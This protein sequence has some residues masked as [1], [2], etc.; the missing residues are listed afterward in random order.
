MGFKRPRVEDATALAATLVLACF[1]CVPASAEVTYEWAR[2]DDTD[3]PP[4]VEATRPFHHLHST[5]GRW[6]VSRVGAVRYVF[7]I[8]KDETTV[9]QY[10][11]FLNAVAADDP[12][13][14]ISKEHLP[15][16]CTAASDSVYCTPPRIVREGSPGSYSYRA[17]PGLERHPVG[18]H[19]FAAA[20]FMNWLHNGQPR[21]PA[22]PDTT[23]SGAYDCVNVETPG[24][25]RF[26]RLAGAR[27]WIPNLHEL[28]K[29]GYWN[30]AT[31]R[32]HWWPTVPGV[33]VD[34]VPLA[35]SPGIN[36]CPNPPRGNEVNT[37]GPSACHTRFVAPHRTR[38]CEFL[39]VA[40]YPATTSPFGLRDVCGQ[41][42][43]LTETLGETNG[44]PDRSKLIGRPPGWWGHPTNDCQAFY[45][46]QTIL[47]NQNGEL[48][49]VDAS[50]RPV[51]TACG[52]IGP[53]LLPLVAAVRVGRAA[54]ARAS[55]RPPRRGSP[56]SH[57]AAAACAS[58]TSRGDSSSRRG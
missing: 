7:E 47:R 19:P 8:S 54:R 4:D 58:S 17:A 56:G 29:A 39:P 14:L 30:K 52:L 9:A 27:Y 1:L 5:T 25:C 49:G 32:W 57:P 3:N 6:H 26:P 44:R 43:E 33:T 50:I 23:E 55:R 46:T 18:V 31:Q 45:V 13:D 24:D 34:D 37:S 22:G 10:V 11:E 42:A 16:R 53:E 2:I 48:A 36:P 51:R 28:H 15:F 40:S 21:G 12:F 41:M 35:C 20:R 38:G